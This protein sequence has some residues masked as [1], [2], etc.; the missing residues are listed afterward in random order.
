MRRSLFGGLCGLVF[1]VNFG[2]TVFAPLVPT[3]Q[4]AFSV[5]PGTIGAVVS[6]VWFGTAVS[7]VPVGYLV[8]LVSRK[9]VVVGT[10]L[11]LA[12]GAVL[13]ATATS[14]LTLL[15]GAF[16][17]GLASGAYFAAAVPVVGELYPESVGRAIGVHGTASQLAAVVAPTAGI[18]AVAHA[19]WRTAFWLLAA[20]ALLVTAAVVVVVRGRP[21][22][23]TGS[24]RLDFLGAFRH[25]RVILT[26]VVMVAA[27]GFVWQGLFN[28]YVPYL[29][30]KGLTSTQAG[31]LQTAVFA[32]GVPAFWYS[33]VLADRFPHGPYLLTILG[34]FT[35]L[36]FLLT[37]VDGFLAVLGVTLAIGYV[38]HS[39]FPALDTFLLDTLPGDT[40]AS[41]YAVYSGTALLIE[42][43][44]SFAVGTLTGAGY[45]FETVFTGFAAGLAAVVAGLTVL[46]LSGN[47][48][49]ASDAPLA[50][51]DFGRAG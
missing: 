17:V 34:S 23:T 5:G 26:A 43:L 47:L 46:Y 35:A 7:R 33:G 16:T 10:G 14:V 1:F 36:L 29:T 41:A 30:A 20:G 9:R 24:A 12:G 2:R 3:L 15:A 27:V 49:G 13:T 51:S 42:S 18:A 25:W 4:S 28:F 48:P 45:G 21:L 22:P 50:D 32:A 31:H 8:T 11:A 19:D 6:L 38:I 44:G 40:R 37:R 39:V